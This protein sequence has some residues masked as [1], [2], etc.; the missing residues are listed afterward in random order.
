MTETEKGSWAICVICAVVYEMIKLPMLEWTIFWS[1][2][3]RYISSKVPGKRKHVLL[4]IANP[5][6]TS[7]KAALATENITLLKLFASWCHYKISRHQICWAPS[8][9]WSSGHPDLCLGDIQTTFMPIPSLYH[10][11]MVVYVTNVQLYCIIVGL[12]IK[13]TSLTYKPVVGKK[14]LKLFPPS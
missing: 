11:V 2:G 10:C 14:L 9:P 1:G 6:E 3:W 13:H 12:W 5:Q 4:L 7:S 8:S